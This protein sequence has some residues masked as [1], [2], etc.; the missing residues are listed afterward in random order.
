[1]LSKAQAVQEHRLLSI[2]A[3]NAGAEYGRRCGFAGIRSAAEYRARVPEATYADLQPYIDRMVDGET[4]VL[5]C[6]SVVNL[7][8]T[9][10]STGAR[11]YVP[12]TA[13]GLDA[14]RRAL[15]AWLDD[16]A[17]THPAISRG[18]SYWAISPAGRAPRVSRGGIPIGLPSDA[19]YLGARLAPLVEETLAVPPAVGALREV[20]A[21]RDRTC[22]N[23]LGCEDL[24]LVSV[25]SPTFLADLLEHLRSQR[26]RLTGMLARGDE[27]VAADRSRAERALHILAAREPDLRALWPHLALVSCW[28]QG[29]SRVFADALRQT[30]GAVPLQGK[31][32]LATEGVVS[33]PLCDLPMPVLAVDSGFYEFRASSGAVLLAG[34]VS[35]GCEYDVLMT[36]ESG[37]YRYAIGD[38]VRVHGFAGEAPLV[39]FIG[40]GSHVSDLCGEKLSEDFVAAGLAPLRLRFALVAP[41]DT[42]SRGY[43]LF[44]DAAE[45][46]NDRMAAVRRQAEQALCLNPQYAYARRLGQLAAVDVRRCERPLETWLNAGCE[47]G[48]RLGVVKLSHLSP[49]LGWS[50]RFKLAPP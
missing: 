44:V 20:D 24:A 22:L 19:G 23:L 42:P 28:D 35:A 37:L 21:W 15:T 29:S 38:R 3:R 11:K 25:W 40:R 48:Q 4:E 50:T 30:L 47:R 6:D 14:F 18:R 12:Y 49:E 34:E 9:S 31:G 16:L 33:I 26:E 5:V 39:E 41:T 46:G 45:V 36:T 43:S 1:M 10:G 32:L 17:M 7:E 2:L 27:G 8:E 13:P